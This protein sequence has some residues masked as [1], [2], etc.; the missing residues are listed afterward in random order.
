MNIFAKTP[1]EKEELKAAKAAFKQRMLTKY[2]HL[3][4]LGMSAEAIWN[5]MA[6]KSAKY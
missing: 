3:A 1:Q 2:S 4:K 6:V 5:K